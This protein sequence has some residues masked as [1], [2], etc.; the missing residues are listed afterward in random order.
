M[1]K[2]T[3]VGRIVELMSPAAYLSF[4]LVLR[5]MLLSNWV[6]CRV[7]FC[8]NVC[9]DNYE[10]FVPIEP[11]IVSMIRMTLERIIKY[12]NIHLT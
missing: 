8:I 1:T 11:K 7:Y 9:S 2:L 4:V 5:N 6:R 3:F 10:I 12:T